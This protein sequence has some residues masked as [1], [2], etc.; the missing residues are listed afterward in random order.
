MKKT[1]IS[2]IILIMV[3]LTLS[4]CIPPGFSKERKKQIT[5]E[6][7]CDAELWFE[8]NLP[9][10]KVKR[11]EAYGDYTNLFAVIEGEY[12]YQGEEYKYMYDYHNNNMYLGYDYESARDIAADMMREYFGEN[13][14]AV[15][16]EPARFSFYTECENDEGGYGIYADKGD[17][18]LCGD[19]EVLPAGSDPVKYADYM[20][21][22]GNED[23]NS[24]SSAKMYVD[25]IPKYNTNTLEI[26]TGLDRLKFVKPVNFEFDGVYKA[27]YSLGSASYDYLKIA[28]LSDGLYGGYSYT[29]TIKYDESGEVISHGGVCDHPDEF[30]KDNGDG[31]YTFNLSGENTNPLILSNKGINISY[32]ESWADGSKEKIY[33]SEYSKDESEFGKDYDKF[34]YDINLPKGKYRQ[35]DYYDLSNKHKFTIKIASMNKTIICCL[36]I[37][38]GSLAFSV[39]MMLAYRKRRKKQITEEE[40]TPPSPWV[41]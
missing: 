33:L 35:Y 40:P 17:T 18:I 37:I 27:T 12:T 8:N 13:V 4:A 39:F 23:M 16:M 38:I 29:E 20:L 5:K 14:K 11:G 9:E 31:S 25:D 34:F 19:F 41:N 6:H 15:D 3:S 26:F 7:A 2:L 10:A 30:I 21:F 1:I 32:T 24:S 22:G 28:K 36:I